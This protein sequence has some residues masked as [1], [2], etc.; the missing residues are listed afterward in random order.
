MVQCTDSGCIIPPLFRDGGSSPLTHKRFVI[1]LD[2]VVHF[3]DRDT[4][5]SLSLCLIIKGKY[6]VT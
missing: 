2:S 6:G 1:R 3:G 4:D 5:R